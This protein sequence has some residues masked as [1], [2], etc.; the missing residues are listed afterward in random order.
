MLLFLY[1]DHNYPKYLEIFGN[2]LLAGG[3]PY[4][5]KNVSQFAGGGKMKNPYRYPGGGRADFMTG[6]KKGL[7]SV[8]AA[9]QIKEVVKNNRSSRRFTSGGKF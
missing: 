5:E 1:N 8:F 3:S 4:L 6:I 2:P 7:N 9:E